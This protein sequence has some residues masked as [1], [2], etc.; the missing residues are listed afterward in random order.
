MAIKVCNHPYLIPSN[1]ALEI[2]E[3]IITASGKFLVLDKLLQE[4]VIKQRKKILIFSGFTGMLD[5][6][7]DFLSLRGGSGENFRY[8]R[9]DGGTPRARRNLGIRLFNDVTSDYRIMLISTRAGG[10]GL[11][12]TAA[13]DLVMLDQD[14][15]P[16]ITL[17]A[18][19]RAHRIGQK[20][21]VTVYKL[22]TQGTV[23]EQMM[24][25]IQ[26]K[27]YLSA[28]VTESMQDIHT[29]QAVKPKKGGRP[30]EV[31]ATDDVPN[32]D[33]S[34]LMTLVRRG[35]QTLARPEI[36][37]NEMLS[38]DWATILEK[39]K[40]KAADAMVTEM[41][42]AKVESAEEAEKN[43]LAQMEQVESR[44]FDGKN[45]ARERATYSDIQQDWASREERR[46]DKNTTVMIDGFAVSK[47]SMRCGDWEAVPTMA[48][49]DPRLAEVK[50][51]K[52][53][54]MKNESHCVTCFDGGDIILCEGCPRSY[55]YK[56]LDKVDQA[57]SKG[58]GK[59][60][61]T[62][63]QCF[64]C[65]QKTGNAGGMLYRC[66]W[67]ERA[68]CEDCMDWDEG[69]LL[70]ETLP[71][72]ESLDY[73]A[74]EQ[75]FYVSCGHCEQQ[76]ANHPDS[77]EYCDLMAREYE[78]QLKTYLVKKQE[79]F[80]QKAPASDEESKVPSRAE[81][82]TDEATIDD[83]GINT[84]R[85]EGVASP[86]WTDYL[87]GSAKRKAALNSGEEEEASVPTKRPR[88]SGLSQVTYREILD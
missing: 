83:S 11:N 54:P 82:L 87:S 48:G 53:A 12:L 67:C 75:A 66:R 20:N 46:V 36:D 41:T 3:H 63:H 40:D 50:R 22:C 65:Q 31:A 86:R 80:D 85:S 42:G 72:F 74:V 61:C 57:R 21:P 17:Q 51:A 5:N 35:A 81:S 1:E 16:Q 78:Q 43:W 52:K 26:K 33:V 27:L 49:K 30:S 8:C 9:L 34:Q 39:C 64:D 6:V 88:R 84:P 23:E 25:R 32:L 71:E 47:E 56:C 19:A 59:Y 45:Y 68:Y 69:K 18:E 79:E 44:V 60:H 77:K 70:G 4:L 2:G 28:K 10:L 73:G 14:W 58:F 15:N 38:W 37:I 24:G 76:F 29:N 62:Q 13:S 7:E 55:H